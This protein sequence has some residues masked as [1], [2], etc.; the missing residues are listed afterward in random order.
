[1]ITKFSAGIFCAIFN[2]GENERATTVLRVHVSMSAEAVIILLFMYISVQF[3]LLLIL[4]IH[5]FQL[6][7]QTGITT[8]TT[9]DELLLLLVQSSQFKV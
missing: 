7:E 8:T 9:T 1:M 2:C 3:F 4:L 5:S 6:C